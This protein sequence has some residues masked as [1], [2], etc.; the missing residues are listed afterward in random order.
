MK[1]SLVLGAALAAMS[2]STSASAIDAAAYSATRPSMVSDAIGSL[3]TVD[4]L[5]SLGTF[6]ANPN[7]CRYILS[8]RSPFNPNDVLQCDLREQRGPLNP[9]CNQNA[10][11]G[12]TPNNA[13]VLAG[14]T[15]GSGCQGF[16]NTGIPFGAVQVILTELPGGGTGKLYGMVFYP[17]VGSPL[18]LPVQF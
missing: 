3:G 16:T 1:K 13:V 5:L 12:G 18:A 9:S 14:L 6:G 10:G 4:Y 7:E 15:S 11:A 2:I 17:A 8:W